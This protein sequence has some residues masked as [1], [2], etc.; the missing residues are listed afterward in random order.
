MSIAVE[1]G[2]LSG[3]RVTVEA[4]VEDRAEALSRRA[5]N[6]PLS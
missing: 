6:A 1:V 3:K 2:L 4:G 5:E